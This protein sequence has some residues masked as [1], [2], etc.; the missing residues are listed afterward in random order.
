M[1][2]QSVQPV[3]LRSEI[4]VSPMPAINEDSSKEEGYF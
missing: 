2:N 1:N 4:S 3:S